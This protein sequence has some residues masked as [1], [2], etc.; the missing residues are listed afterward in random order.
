MGWRKSCN[1]RQL[2]GANRPG[3]HLGFFSRE[4][5]GGAKELF[6]HSRGANSICQSHTI[7]LKGA[8]IQQGGGGANAPPHPLP[9]CG[10][11]IRAS[12]V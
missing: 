11:E 4:G 5:G 10:P 3:Q 9:K 6:Q 1:Y 12:L 2:F 7:N 8:N